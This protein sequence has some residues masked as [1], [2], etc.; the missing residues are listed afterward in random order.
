LCNYRG[1]LLDGKEFDS[2]YRKNQPATLS[3]KG[4]IKG[5]SEA[6]QL[7]P[8]GSKWE[9]FVPPQLGYGESVVGGIAPNATLIFELELISIVEKPQSVQEIEKKESARVKSPGGI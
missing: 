4:V 7:M 6:L 2:S 8:V 3:V 5:I 1:T 9:L